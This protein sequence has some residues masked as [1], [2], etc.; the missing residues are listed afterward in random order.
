MWHDFRTPAGEASTWPTAYVGSALRATGLDTAA[1]GRATEALAA[2]QRPDGGWGYNEHTPADADSTSWAALFLSR[3]PAAHRTLAFLEAHQRRGGGVATYAAPGPVRRFTGLPRWVPFRGW[4]APHV[5]VTA[6]AA[7][8]FIALGSASARVSAA[9][10]DVLS[11]QNADGSW[12]S[13]WWTT[14]HFATREAAA[15]ALVMGDLDIVH[16]AASWARRDVATSAFARSLS[17]WILAVSAVDCVAAAEALVE[18]QQDDGGW[19]AE[20]MLRIPVPADRSPSGDGR[21]HLVRFAGGLQV[22]DQHRTFTSA[23]CVAALA[24]AMAATR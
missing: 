22:A 2:R 5:E 3:V 1:V 8:A 13:Y 6:V 9:W 19:P 24:R 11:R 18:M 7:R 17:L 16:R 23:T 21:G 4:C 12:D 15:L 10:R 20:P 14:P